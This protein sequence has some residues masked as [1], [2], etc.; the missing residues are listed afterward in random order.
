MILDWLIA[1]DTDND[2][3]VEM[4]NESH[5][6]RQSSDWL[7]V[8][9][10]A[11]ENAFVNA[12]LYRALTLWSE[13]EAVLGD[14]Q[15]AADYAAKAEKLRASFIKPIAEGG[16][17]NP[18][19]NWFAYWRN[20]DGSIRGDNGVTPVSFAA[21]AYGL[22]TSEQTQLTLD[23]F[24]ERMIEEALFHWP[25]CFLPYPPKENRDEVFPRYENGDIFLPWG[26]IAVR[27]YV[28]HRPEIVFKYI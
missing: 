28:K 24:E 9:Y 20:K 10:A 21:I 19:K 7:D 16:F 17:W 23:N 6:Q 26:E 18:E 12:L 22:A 3:L 14:S 25:L 11:H 13:C 1:R 27:S 15:K 5:L 8:V 2:G 4:M